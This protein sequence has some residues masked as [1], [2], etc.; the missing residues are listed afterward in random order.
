[1]Y[2]NTTT[3]I[4]AGGTIITAVSW[5]DNHIDAVVFIVIIEGNRQ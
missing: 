3:G 5:Q 1:M 4:A 2:H